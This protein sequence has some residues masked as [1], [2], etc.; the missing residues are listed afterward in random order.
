MKSRISKVEN[1]DDYQERRI[2]V[3]ETNVEVNK[4]VVLE[5]VKTKKRAGTKKS[6]SLDNVMDFNVVNIVNNFYSATS[7]YVGEIS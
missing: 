5:V 2:K 1:E 4:I 3:V 7:I 6:F